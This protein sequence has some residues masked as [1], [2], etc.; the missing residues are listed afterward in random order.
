MLVEYIDKVWTTN[1]RLNQKEFQKNENKNKNA[2]VGNVQNTTWIQQKRRWNWMMNMNQFS[3]VQTIDRLTH[4]ISRSLFRWMHHVANTNTTNVNGPNNIDLDS[5]FT[6]D[7]WKF[8]EKANMKMLHMK[9]WSWR[10]IQ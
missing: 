2:D 6:C 9:S 5:I 7:N 4:I 1:V 3:L 10:A 8:D